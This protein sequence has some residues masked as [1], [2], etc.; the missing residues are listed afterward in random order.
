MLIS[1]LLLNAFCCVNFEEVGALKYKK[2]NDRIVAL[3]KLYSSLV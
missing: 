3:S 2:M 1:T